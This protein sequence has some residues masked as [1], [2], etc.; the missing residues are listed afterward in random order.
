VQVLHRTEPLRVGFLPASDCAPLA[1]AREA[2][3]F[4]K[5]EIEV[6]LVRET[7]LATL[8]DKVIEGDLDAAHVTA[9]LP[10]LA[11]LGIEADPCSCVAGMVLN[12]QGNAITLSKRLFDE[13]VRDAATLHEHIFRSWGKRTYTFGVVF[14][15]SSQLFLLRQWLKSGGIVPETQVRIVVVPPIQMFPTLKLGY[16]DGFCAGEPWSSMAAQAGVGVCVVS[17]VDL[18][19]LHPEKV[20]MARQSFAAGRSVEHERLLAALLE[21]CAACDAPQNR[22]YLADLLAQPHYVNAPAESLTAELNPVPVAQNFLGQNIFHRFNAND[23]T[24]E[25]AAWVMTRLYEAL[26]NNLFNPDR[27]HRTP[28]LKNVFRRDIFERASALV[29]QKRPHEPTG[30]ETDLV[31]SG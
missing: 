10:F 27:H 14:P 13:G 1:Y 22:G 25:K 23:P 7:R 3:L 21:A 17:S 4:H 5:H 29:H 8:R 9:S 18:A 12:L 28:V 15:L 16:L 30:A 2:G 24:N 11:N 20:L 31:A 19:P 26:E 6:E